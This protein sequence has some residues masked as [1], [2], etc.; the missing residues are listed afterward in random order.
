MKTT[1]NLAASVLARLKNIAK[2]KEVTFIEILTR[3]AIERTLK[4]IEL[5]SRANQCILKGGCLFTIWNNGYSYRPTMDADLELRGRGDIDSV[6]DLFREVIAIEPNEPDALSFDTDTL[7]VAQ[8]RVDDKYGGVRASVMAYIANVRIR[9]QFDVG[10]GDAITP[11]ARIGL[12]PSLLDMSEPRIKIYP[13]ATVVAEKIE[14]I[15]QRGISNSRMKDYYDLWILCNDTSLDKVKTALAVK[16]TFSRR[17]TPLPTVCPTGLA[18]EFATNRDK[19]VQWESF[20][21]KSRLDNSVPDFPEI[22]KTIRD[23]YFDILT[24]LSTPREP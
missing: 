1:V 15:V 17:K 11:A 5:S 21:H 9:V 13:K 6:R 16:R 10:I 20:L 2:S 14:T 4:R 22:I 19:I 7:D 3:Y 24:R 18:N 23:F 12:F 8:I